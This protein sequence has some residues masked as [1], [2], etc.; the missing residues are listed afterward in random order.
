MG[1]QRPHITP[2]LAVIFHRQIPGANP[3]T[4]RAEIEFMRSITTIEVEK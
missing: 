4:Q 1:M 2:H 3:A